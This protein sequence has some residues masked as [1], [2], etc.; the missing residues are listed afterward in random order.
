MHVSA[1]LLHLPP[2]ERSVVCHADK[3]QQPLCTVCI[4]TLPSAAFTSLT[5]TRLQVLPQN[6]AYG[7]RCEGGCVQLPSDRRPSAVG[8]TVIDSS[9]GY[10]GR[11]LLLSLRTFIAS[12]VYLCALSYALARCSRRHLVEPLDPD[13]A[14][15]L[16]G[17]DS[18]SLTPSISVHFRF[19]PPRLEHS[20]SVCRGQPVTTTTPNTHTH[21]HTPA[22][23]LPAAQRKEVHS[24]R[25]TAVRCQ[26]AAR[27]L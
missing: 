8:D 27:D 16:A 11:E 4:V 9:P 6:A 26:N 2:V 3:P 17:S 7:R 10:L 14:S 22:S 5:F 19:V 13:R 18:P 12:C 25:K 1:L 20:D 24:G 15:M 21:T 23:I